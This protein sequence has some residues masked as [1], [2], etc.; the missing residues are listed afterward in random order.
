MKLF[1]TLLVGVSLGAC[2]LNAASAAT[3]SDFSFISGVTDAPG[4]G[5]STTGALGTGFSVWTLQTLTAENTDGLGSVTTRTEPGLL[6]LETGFGTSGQGTA[7]YTAGGAVD[8]SSVSA[9]VIDFLSADFAGGDVSL[10]VIDTL[11]NSTG[12]LDFTGGGTL[13]TTS[14]AF[15]ISAATVA[16]FGVDLSSIASLE[17]FFTSGVAANDLAFDSFRTDDI[18]G[19]PEPASLL[20]FGLGLSIIGLGFRKKPIG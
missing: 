10:R 4:G 1:R 3:I 19:V 8:M 14:A 11:A 20:L 15:S 16:G 7:F 6:A 5:S 12:F 9:F 18:S 2:F 17:L 13:G